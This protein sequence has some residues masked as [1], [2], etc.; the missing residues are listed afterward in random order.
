MSQ[1]TYVNGVIKVDTMSRSSAETL[2]LVQT[3]VNHLPVISGSERNVQY[4]INLENGYNTSSNVDEFDKFSNLG[5]GW[6]GKRLFEWQ[7]NTLIT[8]YGALRDRTFEETLR[9]TT[10]TLARLSSRLLV[11]ECVVSVR[12]YRDSFVFNNPEWMKNAYMSD[13]CEKFLWSFGKEK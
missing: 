10:K 9:E 7:T 1:W 3:V 4:Y 6:T 5:N 13:W 12:S 8:M 2:Y 11:D